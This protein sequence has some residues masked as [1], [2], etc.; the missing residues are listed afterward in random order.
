MVRPHRAPS[1]LPSPREST[2]PL[3]TTLP[4]QFPGLGSVILP[5]TMGLHAVTAIYSYTRYMTE[6]VFAWQLLMAASTFW[7]FTGIFALLFS[8]ETPVSDNNLKMRDGK[9]TL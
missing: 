2:T 7:L 4:R 6:N 3:T 8:G 9:K 5:M 1:Q